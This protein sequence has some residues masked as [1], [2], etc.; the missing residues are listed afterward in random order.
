MLPVIQF[1]PDGYVLDG[2]KLMGRQ[3][4]GNGFLRAAI[5]AAESFSE[6]MLLAQ[7]PSQSSAHIFQRVVAS[8]SPTVKTGWV[9]TNRQDLLA[10]QA[11]LFLPGP[12]L[13]AAARQR[14]RAD[15]AAWSLTGATYTICSHAAM[16]AIVDIV[17]APVMPWDALICATSVA[18]HAVKTLFE[19]QAEYLAWRFGIK[20]FVI[21]QLPV[22]PFGTH[23]A[24]FSFTTLQKQQARESLQLAIDEVAVLFAGRLSF[25]AKA[26][27]FPM[28]MAMEQAAQRTG[29][30]LAL[31]LCGQFPNESIKKAFLD[32]AAKYAPHIR[33]MWVDGKDP[34]AYNR[35]W[36]ASD[37]FVSLSDNLQE[38]FGITP[39][40]AMATGLPVLVSDWD[41]YKD[42][43]VDGV[44]GYRIPTWMPPPDL[45]MALAS[46]FEAGVINYDRY[47]G[48]ACLEV[49][50]D[51]QVLID[52]LVELI[53]DPDL[54]ARMGTAG[55]ERVAKIYEWT[56]VMAQHITLWNELDAMRK[57]AVSK[58]SVSLKS[59]PKCAPERQDP[60]RVFA[61]FPTNM[62]GPQTL[63]S[64]SQGIWPVPKWS[65]LIEDPLFNYAKDFLPT[66]AL[67]QRVLSELSTQ[68][69]SIDQLAQHIGVSVADA[70][71]FT[72]P[73]TKAGL[74][75]YSV[76]NV[77]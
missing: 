32:A 33:T 15:P 35:A 72:A 28:I 25:H 56:I 8:F 75:S 18:Q 3:S 43:V 66:D 1:E 42:T 2:P 24:D 65:A 69:L 49:S 47:I 71:K 45:G 21:P 26:H 38:T 64:L 4:A 74:L 10:K 54:R 40:E 58:Q 5:A 62:I 46:A 59:A 77:K 44:T 6:P 29:K 34:T 48:L 19:L 23:Q 68:V 39:V 76:M 9:P 73:L 20:N 36:S 13:A 11:A 53:N 52:R 16:D 61:S 67:V 17:S 7:T 60:Y 14:L 31:L 22:I 51:N 63:V 27:P 41:G 30:K 37:I 50:V 57:E 70:I 55:R 12:G